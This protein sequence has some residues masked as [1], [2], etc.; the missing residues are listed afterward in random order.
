VLPSNSHAFDA[1]T[2]NDIAYL[3]SG[4]IVDPAAPAEVV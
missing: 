3:E 4:V 1:P 2:G